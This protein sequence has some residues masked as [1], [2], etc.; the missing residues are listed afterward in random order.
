MSIPGLT[1]TD[2]VRAVTRKLTDALYDYLCLSVTAY[3]RAAKA[4]KIP[5][6]A[7]VAQMPD[8]GS[9]LAKA[10]E[11][12]DRLV[13]RLETALNQLEDVP[14]VMKTG[15]EMCLIDPLKQQIESQERYISDLQKQMEQTEAAVAQLE[16]KQ[17]T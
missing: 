1:D 8:M 4:G 14:D 9:I 2:E 16:R 17:S 11:D 10:V 15:I 7:S 5:A 3:E 12:R 13:G 6:Y